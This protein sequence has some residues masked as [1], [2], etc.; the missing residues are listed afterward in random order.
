VLTYNQEEKPVC[1][2]KKKKRSDQQVIDTL[3]VIM[4]FYHA[5]PSQLEAE[6]M[7]M[8]LL[9]FSYDNAININSGRLLLRIVG[10]LSL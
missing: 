7:Y 1:L 2:K 8:I 6:F 10:Q 5:T 3:F 9:L 4:D